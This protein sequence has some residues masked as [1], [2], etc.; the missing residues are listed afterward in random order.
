MQR[1]S[2]LFALLVVLIVCSAASSAAWA[3]A[4]YKN[5]GR[6]A[7]PEEVKAADISIGISG[8]ELPQGSGTA[9]LGAKI[10][11]AK[12]AVCHGPNGEGGAGS[13]LVGGK[14]TLSS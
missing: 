12:C 4:P 5:V 6:A 8:K 3:Q 7:T 9:V 11:A 2:R 13:A 14:G 1:L 10:Y